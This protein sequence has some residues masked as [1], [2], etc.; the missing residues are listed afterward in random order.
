METELQD[1]TS[2]EIDKPTPQASE[3]SFTVQIDK[4]FAEAN[5][6]IYDFTNRQVRLKPSINT[7]AVGGVTMAAPTI[8]DF[9]N[10]AHDHEDVDDGGQL[11]EDALALTD[12]T[13]NNASSTKHG[14][15]KKLSN[16]A[17][18][19]LDGTGAFSVPS[20]TWSQLAEST[21]GIGGA[22]FISITITA[23]KDL[24]IIVRIMGGADS[25]VVPTLT[26][27][28]DVGNNYCYRV[29]LSGAAETTGVSSPYVPL[30][31]S[32]T[33]S[34]DSQSVILLTNI[35]AQEKIFYWNYCSS[36]NTTGAA[37]APNRLE[38]TGK[39]ANTAA[40]VTTVRVDSAGNNFGV[41]SRMTIYGSNT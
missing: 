20:A 10:M 17:T 14:F 28:G 9:T 34:K 32:G 4:P 23:A 3:L 22:S 39:W 19:F 33:E 26:F 15:L 40:Q 8:T 18:E 2:P 12:V 38:G 41:G 27:N 1:K 35:T 31:G 25:A 24:M 21:I 6:W 11:D 29:S 30:A 7:F 13:T 5:P 37:T 36:A 16:V